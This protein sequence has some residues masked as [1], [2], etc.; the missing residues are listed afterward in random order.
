MGHLAKERTV[1]RVNAVNVAENYGKIYIASPEF[2]TGGKI[3]GK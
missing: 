1:S 3:Y 2:L